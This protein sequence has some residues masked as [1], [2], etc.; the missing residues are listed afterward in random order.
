MLY[1]KQILELN[2]DFLEKKRFTFKTD[3][4]FARS[5]WVTATTIWSNMW[6]RWT[7]YVA[8]TYDDFDIEEANKKRISNIDS[9]VAKS[10]W[11]SK[12]VLINRCWTRKSIWLGKLE[13]PFTLKKSSKVFTQERVLNTESW[14][15]PEPTS[16]EK[17]WMEIAEDSYRPHPRLYLFKK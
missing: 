9:V 11:I 15:Y 7:R 2:R 14:S 6:P 5:L 1:F 3:V 8:K 17:Q 4:E 10:L 12:S 16:Y 13:K